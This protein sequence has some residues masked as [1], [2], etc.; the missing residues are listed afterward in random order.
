MSPEP[1]NTPERGFVAIEWVAAIAMLLLP[2]FALVATLPTW[3][4]RRHAATVA[5]R[6][7]ARYL[8]RSWPASDPAAAELIAKYVAADHGVA[9]ADVEVRVL[10]AGAGHGDQV[11][12]AVRVRMPAVA[13]PGAP[14][15]AG[16]THS[17][18]AALRVGD[19]RSR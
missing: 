6:E 3:V 12:V 1:R 17:S 13:L 11:R 19:Y 7:A 15:V 16:W 5:A 18:Y 14:A 2:A 8:E 9:P 4:E 10:S